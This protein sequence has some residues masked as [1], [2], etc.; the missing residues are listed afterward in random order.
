[1]IG[2]FFITREGRNAGKTPLI[3]KKEYDLGKKN[4]VNKREFFLW[5]AAKKRAKDMSLPFD[6]EVSDI[7]IPELCPVLKIPLAQGNNLRH[8]ASVDR[9]IPDKGY[10]KGNI[11]VISWQANSMKNNATPE[12]LI[13]FC[14]FY[15]AYL[16]K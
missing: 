1:L 8:T 2:E 5:K 3:G 9:I 12:E 6:L 16:K 10:V 7:I 14:E 13:N 15:L 11:M 4:R